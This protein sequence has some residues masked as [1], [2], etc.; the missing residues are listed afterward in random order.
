M[1]IL[2]I[3][4]CRVIVV[5]NQQTVAVIY[6]SLYCIDATVRYTYQ[7]ATLGLA[8]STLR[9]LLLLFQ[10]SLLIT[11]GASLWSCSRA[12]QLRLSHYQLKS[13]SCLLVNATVE[14]N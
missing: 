7:S 10:A 12:L 1:L 5:F 9:Y 2:F 13:V 11:D 6:Y 4:Y 14:L 3:A 8:A